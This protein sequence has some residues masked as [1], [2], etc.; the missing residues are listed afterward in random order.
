[1]DT[2]PCDTPLLMDDV[3]E[4]VESILRAPGI[5]IASTPTRYVLGDPALGEMRGEAFVWDVESGTFTKV[6]R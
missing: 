1:M 2:L 3:P 5:A 4:V 6:E